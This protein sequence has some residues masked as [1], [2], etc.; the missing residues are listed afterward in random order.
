MLEYISLRVST[1]YVRK[2]TTFNVCSSAQFARAAN[3]MATEIDVLEMR[4]VYLT[5]ILQSHILVVSIFLIA[6]W[7]TVLSLISVR[8][9]VKQQEQYFNLCLYYMFSYRVGV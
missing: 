5:H 4:V 9:K 3:V 2:Y 7:S 1:R 8:S 6:Y